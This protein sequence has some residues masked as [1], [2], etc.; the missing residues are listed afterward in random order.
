MPQLIVNA[1]DFGYTPNINSAILE[2]HQ[3][4]IVTSTTVMVNMPYAAEGLEQALQQAPQLGIGVHINLTHGQPIMPAAEIPTLVDENGLFFLPDKLI[5][6]ANKFDGDE[7]YQEIA[8]QIE[9]FVNITGR[10]PTHLDSHYH[11]AFI[12]PLALEATLALADEYQLPM[13]ENNLNVT[14]EELIQGLQFFMP[15]MPT[16]FILGLKQQLQA[17]YAKSPAPRYPASFENRYAA[18]NNTLG[19]LL[20]ILTDTVFTRRPVEI[21]CHPGRQDDPLISNG[22]QK[23]RELN[24]LMHPASREVIERMNIEL[25]SFAAFAEN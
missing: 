18:P 15:Y 9:R 11:M 21:M 14:D 24:A 10:A 1:D 4:G 19:D 13:R 5:A 8:A 3:K 22:E 25:I 20:N 17:V 2:A 6:A 7:L 23:Q 16:E 12:H